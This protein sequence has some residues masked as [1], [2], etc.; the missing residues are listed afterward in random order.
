[1]YRPP[2]YGVVKQQVFVIVMN[3]WVSSPCHSAKVRSCLW[4][5][6]SLS[7]VWKL[8]GH[9][10][11]EDDSAGT[12]SSLFHVIASLA[13]GCPLWFIWR[14]RLPGEGGRAG[15][16]SAQNWPLSLQPHSLG[17]SVT[18]PFMVKAQENRLYLMMGRAAKYITQAWVQG[19]VKHWAHALQFIWHKHSSI[20][21]YAV[22]ESR[23]RVS[24]RLCWHH[25]SWLAPKSGFLWILKLEVDFS[26]L[27][28]CF[29]KNII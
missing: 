19:G 9:R 21:F 2:Q 17:Q 29:R 7:C 11:V 14:G 22:A 24:E 15:K 5:A 10:L 12:W 4:P 13:A 18:S 16:P 1:M 26:T 8:A 25:H 23:P 28:I 27:W 20:V 3:L 6:G